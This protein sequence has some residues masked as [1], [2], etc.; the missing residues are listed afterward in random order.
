MD[1]APNVLLDSTLPIPTAIVIKS[2]AVSAN[3]VT[4]APPV[5]LGLHFRMV[6]ASL[7]LPI[8]RV[9]QMAGSASHAM[10]ASR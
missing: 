4:P 7:S 5:E 2:M 3:Q 1:L 9:T 8:A 6:S 10:M